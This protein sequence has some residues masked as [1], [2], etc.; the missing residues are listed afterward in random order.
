[1]TDRPLQLVA[2][3]APAGDQPQ[4]IAQLVDGLTSGLAKQT[5]LG[6][7]GSRQDV[8]D[9]LRHQHRAAADADPRA[10]QDARGAALRR[11]A[12]VLS[13]QRRRVLRFVLRLLPA[14]GLRALERHVHREGRVDQQPHRA[15][16]AVGDESGARAPRR[17]HRRDGVGDLRPRRS[18]GVPR[19]GAAPRAR[20]AAEP[21][22]PAAP[23]DGAPIRAQPAR[24][25]ARH[26]SR[27]R[28]RHR[29][30]SR[31]VR[32]GRRARRA[33]RRRD[34]A[35]QPLRSADGR[36][37]AAHAARDDL[38]E[39]A[40][41]DAARD[42]ARVRRSDPRR[43]RRCSSSGCAPRTSSSRRSGSSSARASTWR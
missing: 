38:S 4:A 32:E 18:R 7:T 42:A 30:L 1:M 33:V 34:R 17:R 36:G 23:L 26:V 3:F 43:S 29:H 24:S 8:H 2:N 15:D 27:A 41:R 40:L 9:G 22:R 14:R 37:H 25:R 10:Q 6:V 16:A 12:R 21:A 31:G 35:D 20:L 11:D 28:R 19:H 39:D 5:L 13:A